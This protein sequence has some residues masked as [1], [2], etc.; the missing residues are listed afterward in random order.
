M[1]G[2]KTIRRKRGFL[3]KLWECR[4]RAY[5]CRNRGHYAVH[6]RMSFGITSTLPFSVIHYCQGMK[7]AYSITGQFGVTDFD[8]SRLWEE[9]EYAVDGQH[10]AVG[11]SAVSYLKLDRLE[12]ALAKVQVKLILFHPQSDPIVIKT[13]VPLRLVSGTGPMG[14]NFT[15]SGRFLYRDA[16]T[17]FTPPP[18]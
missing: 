16:T 11:I 12:E 2:K 15:K 6:L 17:P 18:S 5:P 8:D 7:C 14:R 13:T 1:G 9:P 10:V 4:L 3:T